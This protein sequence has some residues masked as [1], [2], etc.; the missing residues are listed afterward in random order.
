MPYEYVDSFIDLLFKVDNDDTDVRKVRK[1][2]I[3]FLNDTFYT[4]SNLIHKPQDVAIASVLMGAQTM[5]VIYPGNK[6]YDMDKFKER[7]A[8][9]DKQNDE[10]NKYWF[11]MLDKEIDLKNVNE[12]INSLYQFYEQIR[13]PAAKS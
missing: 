8:A 1:A 9:A 3:F 13:S 7:L 4:V 5:G 6:Y 12:I 10:P 2:T 11:R